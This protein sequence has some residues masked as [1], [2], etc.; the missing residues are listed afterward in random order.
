[1]SNDRPR[2]KIINRKTMSDVISLK[3]W[4]NVSPSALNTTE[5]VTQVFEVS[6]LLLY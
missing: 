2:E 4:E 3:E 6:K 1:M 5:D